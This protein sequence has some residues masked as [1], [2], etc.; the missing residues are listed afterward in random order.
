M[1]VYLKFDDV[2]ILVERNKKRATEGEVIPKEYLEKLNQHYNTFFT[3]IEKVY[4]NFGLKAP[5]VL[6]I[7]ASKDLSENPLYL[8]DC[9]N[10]ILYKI[11]EILGKSKSV[12]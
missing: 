6:T 10:K 11:K 9:A 12:A 1:I 8:R 2:N 3:N 5:E 4:D 7:D